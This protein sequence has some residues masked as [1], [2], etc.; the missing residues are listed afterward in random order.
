MEQNWLQ[1]LVPIGGGAYAPVKMEIVQREEF[2]FTAPADKENK[3][4]LEPQLRAMEVLRNFFSGQGIPFDEGWVNLPE[5]NRC[6]RLAVSL[7]AAT[8]LCRLAIN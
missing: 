5:G 2:V 8:T 7:E 3:E 4:A 1:I 6:D